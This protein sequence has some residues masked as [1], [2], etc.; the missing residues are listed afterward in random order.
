VSTSYPDPS[1]LGGGGLGQKL[2]LLLPAIVIVAAVA[3]LL[4][5]NPGARDAVTRLQQSTATPPAAAATAPPATPSQQP[6]TAATTT[7]SAQ[8]VPPDFADPLYAADQAVAPNPPYRRWQPGPVTWRGATVGWDAP[9][10][11]WQAGEPRIEFLGRDE[12]VYAFRIDGFATG[13]TIAP[14][15][16]RV[17]FDVGGL[18]VQPGRTSVAARPASPSGL[19]VFVEVDGDLVGLIAPALDLTVRGS[20]G[21]RATQRV[22][23]YH[24]GRRPERLFRLYDSLGR[25]MATAPNGVVVPRSL[26]EGAILQWAG[27]VAGSD[28]RGLS[29]VVP[30]GD[31]WVSLRTYQG[32]TCPA[33]DDPIL[34]CFGD[35]APVTNALE[36]LTIANRPW[37]LQLRGGTWHAY[38]R[39]DGI[40]VTFESPVREVVVA[41]ADAEVRG[42]G[43]LGVGR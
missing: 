28:M 14:E 40:Y 19:E 39:I 23:F 10:V 3:Y 1:E 32:D 4:A 41:A 33:A 34:H 22:P 8:A 7:P 26:P 13:E 11:D 43:S 35:A 30:A 31:A 2:A 15:G 36:S 29:W 17:R 12:N 18:P 21:S 37:L 25:T 24:V 27:D 5:R 38:A 6:T 16:V 20:A 9:P 42:R